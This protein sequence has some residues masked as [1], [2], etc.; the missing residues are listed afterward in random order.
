MNKEVYQNELDILIAISDVRKELTEASKKGTETKEMREI[1]GRLLS[2][3][4]A[5]N[6]ENVLV[7]MDQIEYKRS[8]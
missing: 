3:Y 8:A 2:L 7:I 5:L 1:H 6:I 4:A